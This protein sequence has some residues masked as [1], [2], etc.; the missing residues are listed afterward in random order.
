MPT[1]LRRALN[2]TSSTT[3]GLGFHGLAVH[4]GHV[5]WAGLVGHAWAVLAL[6][7]LPSHAHV[8]AALF[9]PHGEGHA[10]P[11]SRPRACWPFQLPQVDYLHWALLAWGSGCSQH[12]ATTLLV[13]GPND[14]TD[15]VE[16][17]SSAA[18][19]GEVVV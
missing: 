1:G 14:V 8:R 16:K 13:K 11:G 17:S 7:R 6:R 12:A 10:H 19:L 3:E 2:Y 18:A 9:L 15:A 5:A 4:P